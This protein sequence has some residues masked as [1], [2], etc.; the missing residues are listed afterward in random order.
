MDM[1]G[2]GIYVEHV[3]GLSWECIE[4]GNQNE[5]SDGT[6]D[7]WGGLSSVCDSCKFDYNFPVLE[8]NEDYYKD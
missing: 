3:G 4:C 7:D 8:E 6:I 2:S 5:N 1:R